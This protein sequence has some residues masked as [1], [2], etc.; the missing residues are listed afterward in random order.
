MT[1]HATV[2]RAAGIVL[3]FGAMTAPADL[4][5]APAA[6]PPNQPPTISITSMPNYSTLTKGVP[7]T[8]TASAVDPDGRIR[9]V[10]FFIGSKQIDE[11]TRPPYT[12]RWIPRKPGSYV[13]TVVATDNRGAKVT[14][15]PIF[16]TVK[17]N[18]A[19]VITLTS[20]ADNSSFK[21]GTPITI[22]AAASDPGG[23]IERVRFYI[24]GSHVS[25]D[26]TAPYSMVWTGATIGVH[27]VKAVAVDNSSKTT[28]SNIAHVTIKANVPP[29]VSIATPA[30]GATYTTPATIALSAN[31]A[32]SDGSVTQVAYF[33]LSATG[34]AP[35]GTSQ[36][37]PYSVSWSAP[38]VGQYSFIAIATDN[39]GAIATS[40]PIGVT[41]NDPPPPPPPPTADPTTAPLVQPANLT[42][43]GSF[44]V[45]DG[46]LAGPNLTPFQ[47][48]FPTFNFGSASIAYNA[49]NNSLFMV[50][51]DVGQLVSEIDI[52][53]ATNGPT[54]AGLATATVR[55]PFSDVTDQTMVNAHP[56]PSV[57]LKVGG[58]LPYAD[59]LYVSVYD[60]YDGSGTQVKSHFVSGLDLSVPHDATGPYQVGGVLGLPGFAGLIDGY[61]GLVPSEWQAAFGGAVLNGNCCLGVISRTSYG[62]SLFTIDPTAIGGAVD[63][64]PAKA[65]V[66]YPGAHPLL[67]A[68]ISPCLDA[69]TCN[70][71]VDGWSDN[72]SLFNGSTEIRGVVFPTGTRSVLFFGRHGG[73]GTSS[74]L[75]GGGNFCYGV[76]T[77][78]ATL[79]GQLDPRDPL[80]IDRFCYDPEDGNKGVH[81]Y[82]YKYYVW[83]YDANDLA[84]VAAGNASPWTVRPYAVWPL[85]LP[86]ATNG[87][88][89]IGGASYDAAT[90]RIF[91]SQTYGDGTL[92]LI[93][94]FTITL[95]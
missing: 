13:I 33:V 64:L 30:A 3:L 36:I 27:T 34:P 81:G 70:P 40:A 63:P 77:A 35:V 66:Y 29:T 17:S 67:D 39:S 82:P 6:K 44:R 80:G 23:S 71:I 12:C 72:S 78:D 45:P 48:Q 85:D 1:K 37:A 91:V 73:F 28:T 56:L 43:A 42:Y 86:F 87:S 75:P 95:P 22:A 90:G 57:T 19:P 46:L 94:V 55:Q 11:D 25:S 32:D 76:G 92:P 89:H 16:V 83:A 7:Y 79:V 52:P 74:S 65:L 5:A 93:H 69:T 8:L 31:A 84:G 50:G 20:P 53:T 51:H 15:P 4:F 49:A 88:T 62:P 41:V 14:A 61:F 24:D 54:V 68:G 18:S 58:L 9:N 38:A 10:K 60:Y 26:S 47:S 59:R 2:V 21:V